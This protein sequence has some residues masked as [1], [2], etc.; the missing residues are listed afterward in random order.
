M[1]FWLRI[2]SYLQSLTDLQLLT[3]IYRYAVANVNIITSLCL[4][5]GYAGWIS[6]CYSMLYLYAATTFSIPLGFR[7]VTRV[8]SLSSVINTN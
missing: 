3:V 7:R 1:A 4:T 8:A 6:K 2:Y 5:I